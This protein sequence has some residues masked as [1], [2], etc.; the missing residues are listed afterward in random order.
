MKLFTHNMLTSKM[1][2][3]VQ[4]GYPLKLKATEVKNVT[5]EFQPTLVS[6]VLPRVNWSALVEATQSLGHGDAV[7][8]TLAEDYDKNEEFLKM[9]HHALFE[10]EVITGELECPETGRKFKIQRGI[11]N[12]LVNEDEV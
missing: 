1:I 3:N 7:P 6:K 10:I 11:P 9:A 8:A 2:K 12:M 4:V 5:Q